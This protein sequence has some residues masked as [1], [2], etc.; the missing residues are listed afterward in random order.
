[1]KKDVDKVDN[2]DKIA[3]E[4]YGDDYNSGRIMLDGYITQM[5]FMYTTPLC[6]GFYIFT[7]LFVFIVFGVY[8]KII[9]IDG[10][11]LF[12]RVYS[13]S[14]ILVCM[15]NLLLV[16]K[17]ESKY[18]KLSLELPKEEIIPMLI[19]ARARIRELRRSLLVDLVIVGIL[20]TLYT[21]FK[22]AV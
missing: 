20:C 19:S 17:M 4:C 3:K 5:L 8:L 10:F 22:Y 16:T 15:F 14:S 21:W 2:L 7:H 6:V 13:I 12:N 18:Y 9:D 1:M 11:I